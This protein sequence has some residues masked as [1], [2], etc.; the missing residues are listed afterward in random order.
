[1]LYFW[2][3]YVTK[4]DNLQL[5]SITGLDR[6][7]GDRHRCIPNTRY[8][9]LSIKLDNATIQCTIYSRDKTPQ[10]HNDPP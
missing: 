10:S 2:E 9:I 8:F 1:V 3:S 5:K 6:W 4:Y 7:N